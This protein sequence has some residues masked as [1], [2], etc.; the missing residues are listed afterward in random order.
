MIP[1]MMSKIH[2]KCKK[3]I[4]IPPKWSF[5]WGEGSEDCSNLGEGF[6]WRFEK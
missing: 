6:S 4:I 2:E 1:M 3:K 5:F